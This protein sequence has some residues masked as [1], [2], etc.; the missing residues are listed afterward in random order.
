MSAPDPAAGTART[1][2]GLTQ[3]LWLLFLTLVLAG[4]LFGAILIVFPDWP[5]VA[6]MAIPTDLALAWAI[7]HAVRRSGHGW[8][9]TLFLRPL[10]R[11]VWVPLALVAVGSLT[12]FTELYVVI[13]RLAP[14]PAELETVLRDLMELRGGL[15]TL[16][17]LG[18]A[19]V[20]APALEEALF[21]GAL[22]HGLTR[23]RGPRS[24]AVWT[25]ALFALFHVYNPW[26]VLPTFF[27]GLVLAWLV[28]STGSLIA[29]FALHAI[30]NAASL[31]LF[32]FPLDSLTDAGRWTAVVVFAGLLGGSLALLVGLAWIERATDGGLFSRQAAIEEPAYGPGTSAPP[33]CGP[34]TARG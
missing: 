9:G 11:G 20:L 10:T 19:V 22:L 32:T 15:D 24:A 18:I 2:P 23:Q 16:V 28:L 21:R 27:L 26:Q 34:T 30:F 6:Q 14:V 29:P 3:G 17:T 31:A 5:K 25:S 12:V 33:A 7:A 4:L 8:R 1:Y 13:Q